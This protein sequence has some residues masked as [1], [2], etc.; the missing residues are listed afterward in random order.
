ML[1]SPRDR[2][3][4]RWFTAKLLLDAGEQPR[5]PDDKWVCRAWRYL[6]DHHDMNGLH[7]D[8]HLVAKHPRI[9]PAVALYLDAIRERDYLEAGLLCKDVTQAQLAKY[10][11]LEPWLVATYEKIFFNVSAF[12]RG[13]LRS[14]VFPPGF[15]DGELLSQ[16]GLGWLLVGFHGGFEML[17][18]VWEFGPSSAKARRFF[19]EA[20]LASLERTFALGNYSRPVGPDTVAQITNGGLLAMKTEADAK[21]KNASPVS[22]LDKER[23]QTIMSS[24]QFCIADPNERPPAREPRLYE[25]AAQAAREEELERLSGQARQS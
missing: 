14:M 12:P 23:L 9:Q 3:D 4:W 5:P 19:R 8:A 24:I 6:S 25:I 11:G 17:R 13:R 21:P 1:P 15:V 16:R 22:D 2:L 10:L 18:E 7:A 20:G